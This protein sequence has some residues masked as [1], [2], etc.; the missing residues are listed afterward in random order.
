MI[1]QILGNLI[2]IL[3]IV[4][5]NAFFVASEWAIVKV[6]ASQIDL[7]IKKGHRRAEIAKHIVQHLDAYLSTTQL[8]ITLTSLGLGWI[9]E[10]LLA[11]MIRDPLIAC[12]ISNDQTVHAIAFVVSFGILTYLQIIIGELAPRYLAIQYPEGTSLLVAYPLQLFNRVFRPFI[13]MLTRSSNF[14]IS[15]MGISPPGQ[16][17]ELVHSAEELEYLVTEGA[18]SGALNK[19]E[20]EMISSIFEFST[21]T[22]REIMVPR[23]DVTA[24]DVELPRDR[25]IQI[26]TEEGYSRLPVY[27][28][29]LD[30]IIGIIYTKDLISLLQH[31]DLIVL[32]DIIRPAYFIPESMK[33]SLLM[34]DLQD[35][36]MHM[37]VAV[38]E[39]GGTQGIVTMEDILEEIVGEIHDEYDEVRKDIEQTTEGAAIINPRISIPDFNEKFAEKFGVTIPENPDYETIS[40]FLS[41]LTGHIPE[42]SEEIRFEKLLF[43][44]TR[45]TQRRIRQVRVRCLPDGQTAPNRTADSGNAG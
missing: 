22:A 15:A 24:I 11:S 10:P 33:I 6:R 31:R 45:K 44:V 18:K 41:K 4:L 14:L 35:R 25:V 5:A 19:T 27:K 21:T 32:Q 39:F 36:K 20:Q 38:D 34:K 12:G 30:N 28:D 13:W 37:A 2:F 8:G 17:M 9:G 3:L 1:S 40:G 43:T 16:S 23:T 26:V 29:S 7:K 42:I